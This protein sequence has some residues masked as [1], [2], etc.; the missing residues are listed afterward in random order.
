[1]MCSLWITF[2]DNSN[3]LMYSVFKKKHSFMFLIITVVFLGRFILFIPM[4][5]G[6]NTLQYIYIYLMA[7]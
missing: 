3:T 7:R 5:T 2:H 4:E 1:M 6:M